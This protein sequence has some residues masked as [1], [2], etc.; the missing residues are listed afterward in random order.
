MKP[1]DEKKL[2]KAID[3]G[4]RVNF[5]LE[6]L[7]LPVRGSFRKIAVQDILYAEA[8]NLSHVYKQT[9]HGLLLDAGIEPPVSRTHRQNFVKRFVSF[10]Q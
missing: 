7:T 1:V 8:V 5:R 10:I 2:A 9:A 3:W 4:L 6:Q